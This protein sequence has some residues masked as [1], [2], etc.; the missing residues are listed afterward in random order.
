MEYQHILA[1]VDQGWPTVAAQLS[2]SAKVLAGLQLR[3]PFHEIPKISL[4]GEIY[5]RHDPISLQSLIERLA[6]KGFAVR[7]APNG[8]WIKYLDWLARNRIEGERDLG[9]HIRYAVKEYLNY[10]IRKRLQPSNLFFMDGY[11]AVEPVLEAGRRFISPH[12]TGEAILTVG[13]AL[14]DILH[15][16]CGVISIGPFGCMPSR[17]AEAVLNEKFTTAVKR[18]ITPHNGTSHFANILNRERKLPFM[19][20]ETDGNLFPQLIEARLEAFCLQ[21]RRINEMMLES[22]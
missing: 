7:T 12:F 22:G 17:V 5:V 3:R 1:V 10:R 21:A 8:E 16:S 4:V 20:I 15:P 2:R 18:D 11:A 14:H 13:S 19:A 9:F 6:D